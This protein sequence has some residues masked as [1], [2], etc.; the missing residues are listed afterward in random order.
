MRK[1]YQEIAR[2]FVM[3]HLDRTDANEIRFDAVAGKGYR[4][5]LCRYG[6]IVDRLFVADKSVREEKQRKI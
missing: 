2:A 4:V 3:K 5:T 1:L 6:E